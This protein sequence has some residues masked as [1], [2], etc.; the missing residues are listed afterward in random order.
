MPWLAVWDT[1]WRGKQSSGL[2]PAPE[3]QSPYSPAARS[4]SFALLVWLGMN[5]TGLVFFQTGFTLPHYNPPC[6]VLS[7]ALSPHLLQG[8]RWNV[9]GVLLLGAVLSREDRQEWPFILLGVSN[10][11]RLRGG[12]VLRMCERKHWKGKKGTKREEKKSTARKLETNFKL[13]IIS[14]PGSN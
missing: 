5:G 2:D 14:H 3:P 7:P 12:D 9:R 10:S 1:C 11:F 6:T 8:Q 13:W 4:T